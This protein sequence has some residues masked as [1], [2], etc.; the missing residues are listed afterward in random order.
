MNTITRNANYAGQDESTIE[1]QAKSDAFAVRVGK[2]RRE[3]KS[4]LTAMDRLMIQELIAL[5]ENAYDGLD[6]ETFLDL[7]TEDV[8]YSS[9]AFGSASGHLGMSAWYDNFT[10]TFNGKRHLMTNFVM[11]GTE[12]KATVMSY[13][14]VFERIVNS[15]MVASA[16]YHDEFVKV[17][18]TWKLS[19]RTLILDPGMTNTE[20]GQTLIKKYAATQQK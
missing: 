20:Y 4:T 1:W 6:K 13:L 7:M 12:E 10:R 3:G 14:T 17:R 8:Q 16:M 18:G 9:N 2:L 15:D 5:W 19:E 11:V